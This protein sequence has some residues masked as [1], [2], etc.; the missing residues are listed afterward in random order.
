MQA[1]RKRIGRGDDHRGLRRMDHPLGEDRAV[2]GFARLLVILLDRGNEPD[3]RVIG[4]GRDVG[5]AHHLPGLAGVFIHNCGDLGLVDRPEAAH[6][7]RMSTAQRQLVLGP[8]PVGLLGAQNRPDCV[9]DRDHRIDD[10]GRFDGDA[11]PFAALDRDFR[12]DAIDDLMQPVADHQVAA[13]AHRGAI[14][15]PA[16]V[17]FAGFLTRLA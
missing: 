8:R 11:L 12:G 10:L 1:D 7:A 14:G 9:A 3:I 6:E 13:F 4:E 2:P 15:D 17:D 16:G 5:P